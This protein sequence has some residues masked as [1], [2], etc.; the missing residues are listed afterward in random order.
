M[1]REDLGDHALEHR[2]VL[3]VRQ[4]EIHTCRDVA[5]RVAQV[6][7]LALVDDDVDRVAL[8]DHQ[9]DGVGELD[10]PAPYPA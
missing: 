9:F 5:G 6:V 1:L 7:A 3:R 8:A 2:P 10:L 4:A